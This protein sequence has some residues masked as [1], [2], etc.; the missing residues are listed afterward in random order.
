ME[1][2]FKVGDKIF[3]LETPEHGFGVIVEKSDI[4]TGN[5]DQAWHVKFENFTGT[6]TRFDD[7]PNLISEEIYN[8]PLFQALREDDEV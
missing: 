6:I 2:R 7:D 3:D 1:L 8:S 5:P 4:F